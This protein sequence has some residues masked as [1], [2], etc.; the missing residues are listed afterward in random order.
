MTRD[1]PPALPVSISQ[2]SIAGAT[3]GLTQDAV[4]QLYGIGW[5]EDVVTVSNFPVLIY[6][7][8]QQA[9]YFDPDTRRAIILTTWNRGHRTAAGVG[10]CSSIDEVR[11]AYGA[12]LK[13]SS[14]NTSEGKIFAYTVGKNLLFAFNGLPNPSTHVT[15]VALYDGDGPRNDGNGVDVTSGTL[16]FAAFT[17]LNESVCS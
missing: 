17:A 4:K 6:A 12:A 3:L 11:S 7:H 10:P 9:I 16:P 5:R 14:W 13:P 2:A 1:S 8:R 15:A